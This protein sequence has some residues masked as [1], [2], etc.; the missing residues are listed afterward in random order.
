MLFSKDRH[1]L[2]SRPGAKESL[3]AKNPNSTS[4]GHRRGRPLR[5]SLVRGTMLHEVVAFICNS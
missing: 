2:T 1:D 5:S 3:D 4:R